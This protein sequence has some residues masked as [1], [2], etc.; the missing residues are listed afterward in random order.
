MINNRFKD[1]NPFKECSG[2][3]TTMIVFISLPNGH[4]VSYSYSKMLAYGKKAVS[5]RDDFN[6]HGYPPEYKDIF[7]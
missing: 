6:T 4:Y 7:P 5:G 1:E 2:V 3:S